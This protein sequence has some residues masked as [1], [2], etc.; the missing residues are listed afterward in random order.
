[1]FDESEFVGNS[2]YLFACV[3]DHFLGLYVSLNSFNELVITS[4][5]REGVVKRFKP[6]AGLQLLL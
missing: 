3:L 5:Q 1:E 4:K 2:V 6:R